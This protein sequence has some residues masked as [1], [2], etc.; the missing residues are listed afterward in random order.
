MLWYLSRK[1]MKKSALLLLLALIGCTSRAPELQ[2]SV[3]LSDSNH[4]IH[5]TGFDKAIIDDM[6]GEPDKKTDWFG[7]MK[8][9]ISAKLIEPDSTVRAIAPSTTGPKLEQVPTITLRSMNASFYGGN[10]NK[11]EDEENTPYKFETEDIKGDLF[12][13]DS[14]RHVA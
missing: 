9:M 5:I 2:V 14:W 11:P 1:H 8:K 13:A 12:P 6:I 7:K 4:S 3:K 10:P